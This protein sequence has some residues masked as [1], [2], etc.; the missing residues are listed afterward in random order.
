MASTDTDTGMLWLVGDDD[1]A[2]E[3]LN[4]NRTRHYQSLHP[5]W[6]GTNCEE[7][8]C[9]WLN[10]NP[11][12]VGGESLPSP[13]VY[14]DAPDDLSNPAPWFDELAPASAEFLGW[15]LD[16]VDGFDFS[17]YGRSVN[18]R[19]NDGAN[20]TPMRASGREV[21]YTVIGTALSERGMVYGLNW[22]GA[23]LLG[24][25]GRCG[26]GRAIIRTHCDTEDVT[27]GLYELREVALHVAPRWTD[28]Q[29]GDKGC[30]VRGAQ[31][32]IT[33]G[34]PCLYGCRSTCVSASGNLT[35]ADLSSLCDGVT[36]S[37]LIC[38]PLPVGVN[39][40]NAVVCCEIPAGV[41]IDSRVATVQID[42]VA[43]CGPF[44]I[45][46]YTALPDTDCATVVGDADLFLGRVSIGFLEAGQGALIDGATGQVFFRAQVNLP[47]EADD[48]LLLFGPDEYPCFPRVSGCDSMYVAVRP[49][50]ACAATGA[51]TV[52][53]QSV[54]VSQCT[55][56]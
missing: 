50:T 45:E 44:S 7:C 55:T 27:G 12:L 22:L 53:I 46:T 11:C 40:D 47:W 48:S 33:A 56:C 41:A 8:E 3:V 9:E 4:D 25:G 35:T 51:F 26:Y 1:V 52:S 18:Q 43:R 32:T 49:G 14:G 36:I 30:L 28:S 38:G 19:A 16:T 39:P 37:Q 10:Y 29:L 17:N 34:D 13:L 24:I 2:C 6:A 5:L 31:F 23:T 21:T 20:L 15:M 54:A 42:A